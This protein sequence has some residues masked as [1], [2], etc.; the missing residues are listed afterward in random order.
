MNTTLRF[1]NIG[2]TALALPLIITNL[3][4]APFTNGSFES[5][6]L[7]TE[8]YLILAGG[9]TV[10]DGWVIGGTGLVGFVNGSSASFGVPPADGAQHI[11]F[12]GGDLPPDNSISQTFS[13]TP[14]TTYA[15]S[16]NVG[17]IGPGA[18]VQ[19]FTVD[20]I[21][22][23]A[24]LL[25]S[26]EALAPD[27]GGGYGPLQTFKFK[28]ISATTTLTFTD[29]SFVTIATD[30]LLDNVSVVESVPDAPHPFINGSFESPVLPTESYLILTGGST[31]IDGWEIEGTGLV[32]FVN[33][34]ALGVAPADG[35]QHIG[36]NGGDLPPGNSIS[37]TFITERNK[38]YEVSFNVGR[39]GPGTGVQKFTVEVV[40]DAGAVLATYIAVAPDSQ[41]YG[42]LQGFE[43]KARTPTT[44]LRFTD[45]SE[46]TIATDLL[47]DNA[48]V[49]PKH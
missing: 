26:Y 29:T 46:V 17:R 49:V 42:P 7:P 3:H 5:P 8:S 30:M 2:S 37:Q 1:R 20:V 21:S 19:K 16:F 47:L 44:T 25:K 39:I 15:I 6:V 38:K 4:A 32:G 28:A 12:N 11:G 18:G 23:T 27:S 9:S 22:D 14:G 10:I 43:F 34:P 36:F 48:S 31:Q 40:S 33:G 13:T 24:T 35:A 41:G 45:T